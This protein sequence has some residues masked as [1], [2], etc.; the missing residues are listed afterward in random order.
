MFKLKV[1]NAC[2]FNGISQCS[3]DYHNFTNIV[4][5]KHANDI[6]QLKNVKLKLYGSKE[7]TKEIMTLTADMTCQNEYAVLPFPITL[8]PINANTT[9]RYQDSGYELC[10]D[11]TTIINS[12]S[13]YV[14]SRS[15]TTKGYSPAQNQAIIQTIITYISEGNFT[16]VSP[17]ESP[18]GNQNFNNFIAQNRSRLEVYWKSTPTV[19][20]VQAPL[21]FVQFSIDRLP[22]FY[23][24]IF[25]GFEFSEHSYQRSNNPRPSN[26]L[27]P[28]CYCSATSKMMFTFNQTRD[29]MIYR[30]IRGA[31][32][33]SP[34]IIMG[35][36]FHTSM[37]P[38]SVF[39]R[40]QVYPGVTTISGGPP[41]CDA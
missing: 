14:N 11:N 37:I 25:I 27:I 17:F 21:Q 30:N 10:I 36:V 29:L 38:Y 3:R 28:N 34:L 20:Y 41:M 22:V 32:Y 5:V 15:L 2:M 13:S 40:P 8:K 24:A 4:C 26:I 31:S 6:F 19:T 7:E 39:E 1:T 35:V 9:T 33:A 23:Q 16:T 12:V 18:V